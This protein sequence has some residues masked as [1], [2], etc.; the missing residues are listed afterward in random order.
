VGDAEVDREVILGA[1]SGNRA[2]EIARVSLNQN[3]DE[4]PLMPTLITALFRVS[5]IF[6][7]ITPDAT[8]EFAL[9]TGRIPK[10]P[11]SRVVSLDAFL[12]SLYGKADAANPRVFAESDGRIVASSTQ[13]CRRLM[14]YFEFEGLHRILHRLAASGAYWRLQVAF[15]GPNR[16]IDTRSNTLSRRSSAAK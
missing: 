6:G 3:Q 11:V 10:N 16:T 1:A 14:Q 9:R 12:C 15:G 5:S 8:R 7:T 4:A 13:R 2:I